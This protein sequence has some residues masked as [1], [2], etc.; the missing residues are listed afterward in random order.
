M[1]V[2]ESFGAIN[3]HFPDSNALDLSTGENSGKAGAAVRLHER[4]HEVSLTAAEEQKFFINIHNGDLYHNPESIPSMDAETLFNSNGAISWDIGSGRGERLIELARQHPERNFVGIESHYRSARIAARAAADAELENARFIRADAKSLFS[5]I[6]SD[7][8]DEIALL[9]PAPQHNR[10]GVFSDILQPPLVSNIAR[11]LS[12]RSPFEFATDSQPYFNAKMRMI[13]KLGLL[14][15][16][17]E[18][19]SHTISSDQHAVRTR[20]QQIWESKGLLTHRATLM[21]L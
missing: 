12:D 8:S 13:G 17:I 20:Y 9:F 7:S 11:V 5:K 6:P 3:Q 18:S 16:D 4:V 21:R 2:F 19:I 1:N 10:R 14:S 15:C